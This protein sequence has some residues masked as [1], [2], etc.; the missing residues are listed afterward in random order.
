MPVAFLPDKHAVALAIF[1]YNGKMS[2]GLLGDFDAMEDIDVLAEGIDKSLTELVRP[3]QGPAAPQAGQKAECAA[4][5][6]AAQRRPASPA[7]NGDSASTRD[8]RR[9]ASR[10]TGARSEAGCW[11][12]RS[13]WLLPGNARSV[14]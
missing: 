14:W 5:H 1:S 13:R 2:F 3:R 6:E 7:S 10:A 12:N 11:D 8:D 9:P 4:R